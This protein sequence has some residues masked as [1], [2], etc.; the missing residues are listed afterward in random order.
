MASPFRIFR[1][2]QKKLLATL[3]IMAIVA[4]CVPMGFIDYIR[5]PAR[6]AQA[7]VKTSK[8]G[9][10]KE[11]ELQKLRLR[12][13]KVLDFLQRVQQAVVADK[14]EAN[15]QASEEDQVVVNA[16]AA[17]QVAGM[18]GPA[19]EEAVVDTWLYARHAEQ[20]GLVVSDKAI[21]EFLK[22]V[23][24]YRLDSDQRKKIIKD[25]NSSQRQLFELLRHELLALQVRTMFWYSLNGTT[26]AQRW[27]YYTRLKRLATIEV[28]PVPVADYVG[29]VKDPPPEVVQDFFD[30][31]KENYS[32]PTSP[33]PGFRKPHRIAVRYF[34]ADI[35]KFM[36]PDVVTE[37]EVRK[38]YQENKE[39]FDRLA[40]PATEKLEAEKNGETKK[41]SGEEPTVEK[42][43][44]AEEG[45][46][47]VEEPTAEKKEEADTEKESS[48]EPSAD[49]GGGMEK[50]K[51]SPEKPVTEDKKE[52][53]KGEQS[54]DEVPAEGSHE[55]DGPAI[56][57]KSGEMSSG[58]AATP[59]SLAS[60]L[61]EEAERPEA[62]AAEP[63]AEESEQPGLEPKEP[64]AEPPAPALGPE[65]PAGEK[66]PAD[67]KAETA[68]EPAKGPTEP[69]PDVP[70]KG[71]AEE[72]KEP[73]DPLAGPLGEMIRRQLAGQKIQE[74]F[75]RLQGRMNRY[76]NDWVRYE[77]DRLTDPNAKRP[78]EPNFEALAK[79]DD[80]TGGQ[81]LTTRQS[82]LMSQWDLQ[83]EESGIGRSLVD[84][85]GRPMAF[86]NYAFR[87]R[88]DV[89]VAAESSDI[90]EN[91]LERSRYLFWKVKDSKE[92]VPKL[93]DPG[94]RE[95]V[96]RTWKMVEARKLATKAAAEL[97]NEARKAGLSLA[98]TFVDRPNIDVI[99]TRPFSWMTHGNVPL[100]TARTPPRLSEVTGI[101]MAGHDFMRSVFELNKG[102]IGVAM[103]HPQTIAYVIRVAE[104]N[105]LEATLWAQFEVDNY[106]TYMDVAGA[107]QGQM[108]Q[109][110]HDEL[111]TAA[112][113]EWVR[114]PYR[115]RSE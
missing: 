61:Q 87:E 16:R 112:G 9:D 53:G 34:K 28:I 6:A 5:S 80:P 77:V 57:P 75:G 51:E 8:Y 82:R 37:D 70:Q 69:T 35:E 78:Q 103:N 95:Q 10:I 41:G 33:E 27:D 81:G 89:Y 86:A 90:G 47:S 105:P 65:L 74:I 107:D 1:K 54:S 14:L 85:T 31:Y 106:A 29:K 94:V 2:H 43:G 42:E 88:W 91:Y 97:G 72:Q 22:E 108:L 104:I 4:F 110:W 38:H 40:P 13:Q 111:K 30:K 18:I 7:A 115:E 15:R 32:A 55:A 67:E 68:K 109:A 76:R 113:L 24:E 44:E 3:G 50:G 49:K 26:P 60:F 66:E 71:A 20:L 25:I 84:P 93:D 102:Q 56:Q 92:R 98:H 114:P 64:T 39:V 21:N 101:E 12:R 62:A 11:R 17:Q 23:T 96:L 52:G 36:A 48:G 99:S 59:L 73:E 46:A 45:K 83:D 79:E 100:R 58:R 63:P 19:T